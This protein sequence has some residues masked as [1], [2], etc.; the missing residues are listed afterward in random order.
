MA[1][2]MGQAWN[3]L[4]FATASVEHL[5]RFPGIDARQ[6]NTIA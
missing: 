4:V 2:T 1:A 5:A 6:W 3:S